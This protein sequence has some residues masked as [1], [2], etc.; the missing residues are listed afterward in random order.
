MATADAGPSK[1][2]RVGS[3]T[4][5]IHVFHPVHLPG[6]RHFWK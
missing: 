5:E 3:H 6:I 2:N 4:N 1:H